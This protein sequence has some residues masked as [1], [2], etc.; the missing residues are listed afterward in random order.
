MFDL[1]GQTYLSLD[2]PDA[3]VLINLELKGGSEGQGKNEDEG[4][5]DD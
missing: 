4:G 2:Y 3:H 5:G 1:T